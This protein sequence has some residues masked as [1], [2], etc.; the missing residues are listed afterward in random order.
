MV[1][2]MYLQILDSIIRIKEFWGLGA[3]LLIDK[4]LENLRQIYLDE[5]NF[6]VHFL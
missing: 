4:E 6:L 2:T 5:I 3:T 1:I